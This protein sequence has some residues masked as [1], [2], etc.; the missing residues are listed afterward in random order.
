MPSLSKTVFWNGW[1]TLSSGVVY[2]GLVAICSPS[3]AQ[4]AEPEAISLERSTASALETVPE[5]LPEALPEALPEDTISTSEVQQADPP[6]LPLVATTKLSSPEL[7]AQTQAAPR[8][9][10]TNEVTVSAAECLADCNPAEPFFFTSPTNLA[11]PPRSHPNRSVAQSSPFGSAPAQSLNPASPSPASPN[12]VGQ[13]EQLQTRPAD[14]SQPDSSQP[15]SGQPETGGSRRPLTPPSLTF[16]AV[17]LL[18]GDEDSARFRVTGVYPILPELQVGGSLDFTE[19]DV[20]SI[21][22][23]GDNGLEINE[24]Y[25][26]ASL[27]NYPNLRLIVGQL[28]LTSYFDRNSF[29]KDS[30]THFFNPVFATNPALSAAGLGSRQAAVLNWTIIDEIEAKAAVFSSDRNIGDFELN[31]FAGELGGRLGNLILRGTYVTGTDSGADTGFDEIFGQ[32]RSNGDFGLRDGDREDGYGINA[33]YFIPE[34]RL[35]LFAR[36]GWYE[37]RDIDEGGTTYSVGA[38]LLD[39]FMEG[40]RLGLGYGRLLSSHRLREGDNP[41]VLEAFYD[42][43]ILDFLRLGV[44]FQVLDEFSETM[45][46][47]RIRTDFDLIPRRTQ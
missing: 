2:L 29:A 10:V 45:A 38:N 33:E 41:D 17:Y 25:A 11:I 19:G 6:P 4:L 36:Y 39:L 32:R 46:G 16:Q 30:A 8:S 3:A 23:P 20:F 47:F 12:P 15:D 18:Q 7:T 34:I 43:R 9:G 22:D 31:G 21:S 24:L 26:V 40:D 28:D 1:M 14:A 44:T 37:N 42:F 5:N 35:G 27:P 13:A